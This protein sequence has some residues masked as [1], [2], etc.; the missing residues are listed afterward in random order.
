M[1][2]QFKSLVTGARS[3]RR[4]EEEKEITVEQLKELADLGRLSPSG[5]N[6][7][8]LKYI[9]VSKEEVR[10]MVFS[11]LG[12]AGYLK[13]WD[14]PVKGERPA[15][16]IILLRDKG[17]AAKPGTDEGIAA[18]SIFLGAA[19]MGIKGC[20]IGNIKK[21]ELAE[22]LGIE[23]G[24]EIELVIALGYPKEEV[25]IE[26]IKEGDVKYW[27]D[28]KGVHHVPKRSLQE[29]IVKAF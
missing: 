14:G 1:D 21:A 7:Q 4:F 6:L 11:C 24:Y 9:L 19:A 12:W 25:I 16:Y 2:E 22:K 15:G 28:E 18:Q 13:D 20:F 29:V 23:E 17:I 5:A 3:F 26:E 27:R 10:E 8:P